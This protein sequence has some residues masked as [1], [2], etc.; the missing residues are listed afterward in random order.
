MPQCRFYWVSNEAYCDDMNPLLVTALC[1]GLGGIVDTVGN[2]I[3]LPVPGSLLPVVQN[4]SCEADVNGHTWGQIAIKAPEA[5]AQG[6]KGA[7]VVSI[8]SSL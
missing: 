3:K 4:K 6:C 1:K 7:G 5:W 8:K 2:S